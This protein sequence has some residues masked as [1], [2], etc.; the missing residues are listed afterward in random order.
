MVQVDFRFVQAG[1]DTNLVARIV[2][3]L[4]NFVH[5]DE[6]LRKVLHCGKIGVF[7]YDRRLELIPGMQVEVAAHHLA[8]FRPLIERVDR[9]VNADKTFSVLF[10]E[11]HEVGFLLVVHVEFAGGVEQHRIEIIEILG[12]AG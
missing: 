12:V 9:G 1:E 6:A 3:H 10:D 4:V 2:F 7:H 11:L 5:H 8:K